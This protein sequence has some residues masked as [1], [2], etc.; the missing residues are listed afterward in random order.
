MRAT[1]IL[2]V[3]CCLAGVIWV[4][5]GLNLLGGSGMSGHG[6]WAWIGAA[7][8]AAGVALVRWRGRRGPKDSR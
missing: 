6:E 7:T 3:M 2:G 5:Q 1:T 4:A 8:V